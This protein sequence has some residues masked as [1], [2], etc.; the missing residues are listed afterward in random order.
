MRRVLRNALVSL[1]VVIAGIEAADWAA[2]VVEDT[3]GIGVVAVVAVAVEDTAV[4]I[5][6][7]AAAVAVVAEGNIAA[8]LAVVGNTAVE[9]IYSDIAVVDYSYD[10]VIFYFSY[11][12]HPLSLALLV[13]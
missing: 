5:A 4:E 8:G 7:W 2:A 13:L 1:A 6:D 3:A 9:D 10:V 11:L 12:L